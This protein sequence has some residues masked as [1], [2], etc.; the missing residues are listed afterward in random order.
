M[1]KKITRTVIACLSILI[2]VQGV[3]A[4][5]IIADH[6]IVADFESI[7]ASVIEQIK[8]NYN[9]FYGH[10]SH[11]SQI[12]TGMD[13]IRSENSLY[14]YNNGTGTLTLSE[15]GDDLGAEGDTTW[16]PI[17]R[18][19]LNEPGNSI[20]LVIWSWC[21]GVSSTSEEGM[22]IYLNAINQ[23]E[24]D[25]PNVIFIYMTGHLDGSGPTGN[26]YLRN[27][28]I[29]NYCRTNGKVLFDFADIES[30][31]P[32]GT[33]YPDESDACNWCSTWCASHTCPPCGDCAHS[34][35]FNCYLKGK[36][37]WWMMAKI[38]GWN[39][40]PESC[41]DA[42]G[43]GKINLLDVSFIINYLYRGG[44]APNPLWKGDPSG[45]GKINLLDISYLINYLYRGGPNPFC[46][47]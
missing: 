17:T 14:D 15:Y 20:N 46:Q 11:G 9:I 22:N 8:T 32:D 39:V 1:Y 26:L 45:D 37:L 28:Q 16:V 12:V 29:R 7:P 30:Y 43:N 38:D 41:G 36:A 6:T 27:N 44:A 5:E 18:Q 10:T 33:Y 31:A 40:T 24:I 21:G 13:M 2:L 42:D 19:A 23:L 47:T 3:S 35:C 4:Q 34:H 25:Y